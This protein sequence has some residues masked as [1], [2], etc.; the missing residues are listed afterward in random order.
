MT[1][2]TS[3]TPASRRTARRTAGP[4]R[5]RQGGPGWSCRYRAVPRDR[6]ERAGRAAGPLDQA[7]QRAAGTQHRLR[8]RTTSRARGRIRAA[9]GAPPA[10][11]GSPSRSA[12]E[13]AKKRSSVVTVEGYLACAEGSTSMKAPGPE[14][15][16]ASRTF[17]A[18]LGRHTGQHLLWWVVRLAVAAFPGFAVVVGGVTG[19]SPF[20]RLTSGEPRV[21]GQSQTARDISVGRAL[22]GQRMLQGGLDRLDDVARR[23]GLSGHSRL[24]RRQPLEQGL[25][26][27]AADRDGEAEERGDD[28]SDDPPQ[29]V[30]PGV[31]AEAREERPA[32]GRELG[33]GGFHRGGS[34]AH[35]R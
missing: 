10:K 12:A 9:S 28:P 13:A 16:T 3:L 5:W 20:K 6:R 14:F 25:P 35:A 32:R 1:S 27:D 24:A 4:R 30:L 11:D 23:L 15:P 21:P 26:G 29:R 7:A 34:F 22:P 8:P 18:P 2:R 31:A 19:E 17:L 33:P